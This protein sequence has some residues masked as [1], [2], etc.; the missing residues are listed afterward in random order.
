M[1]RRF[2]INAY[3]RLDTAEPVPSVLSGRAWHTND[4]GVEPVLGKD[5]I[6]CWLTGMGPNKELAHCVRVDRPYRSWNSIAGWNWI[7]EG[8]YLLGNDC[9]SNGDFVYFIL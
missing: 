4:S 7:Y 5:D 9:A 6:V 3:N 1:Y 8:T 2:N